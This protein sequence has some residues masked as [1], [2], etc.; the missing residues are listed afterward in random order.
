MHVKVQKSTSTTLP[1]RLSAVRGGELSQP[2]APAKEGRFRSV[3]AC[4][5]ASRPG[6]D[7]GSATPCT[8]DMSVRAA[9]PATTAH[10][11]TAE[12]RNLL[13]CIPTPERPAT[14]GNG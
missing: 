9:T 8:F 4:A 5:E 11:A 2:L 3:D 13:G 1:R 7:S 14:G 10:A 12:T 6:L